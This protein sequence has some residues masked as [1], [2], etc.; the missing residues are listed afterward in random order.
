MIAKS[1]FNEFLLAAAAIQILFIWYD[2]ADGESRF[3][4]VSIDIT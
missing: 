1:A 2:A 4:S 3:F